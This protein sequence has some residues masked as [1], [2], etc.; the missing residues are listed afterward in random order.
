MEVM[1]AESFMLVALILIGLRMAYASPILMLI[2]LR[3]D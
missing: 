3:V 1:S 2:A